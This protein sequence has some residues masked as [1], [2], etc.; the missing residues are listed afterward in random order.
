MEVVFLEN[1]ESVKMFKGSDLFHPSLIEIKTFHTD[2][3]GAMILTK[4][5][6]KHKMYV[7]GS[8]I[9]IRALSGQTKVVTRGIVKS[10]R[11]NDLIL[12]PLKSIDEIISS[13][14]LLRIFIFTCTKTPPFFKMGNSYKVPFDNTEEQLMTRSFSEHKDTK[15]S[16]SIISSLFELQYFMWINEFQNK[17]LHSNTYSAEIQ[18][19]VKYIEANF[20]EKINFSELSKK[21]NISERTFRNAFKESMGVSPK[22]FQQSVRLNMGASKLK[23]GSLTISEI[24]DMLGYYSQFQFSK[25]FKKHFGVTPSQYKKNC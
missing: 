5:N 9:A 7:S 20:N 8:Y 4:E 3:H 1:G 24:S 13:D 21:Y 2:S 15:L 17:G 23:D 6:F 11:Q 14:S 18:K 19:A 16:N 10:I 22:T 25:D 12:Y